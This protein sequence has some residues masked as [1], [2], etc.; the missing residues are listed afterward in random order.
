MKNN[1]FT[2]HMRALPELHSDTQKPRH[3]ILI[4]GFAPAQILDITGPLDVFAIANTLLEEMGM[5][6]YYDI[7][8]AAPE[9]GPLQTTSGIPLHASRSLFEPALAPDTLLISGGPG[10]RAVVDNTDVISA[11]QALCERTERVGS[12]CTGAFPLAATRV[13]NH[14]R[15]TTHWAHFEEFA[16]RFPEV[17]I[18]RDAIFVNDG[19][20]YTSAGISAGIDF[21]LALVESDLGRRF[22]LK[23]AREM[24]VYLKRP[25][26]QSQF[27]A[28]LAL[29]VEASDD[30]RFSDLLDWMNHNLAMDLSIEELAQR[31]AMSPRNFARR[32]VETM[33][34]APGKYVQK[35][36][37]DAARRL[38]TD[39]RLPVSRIAGMCG[40]QSAEALRLA[41]QRELKIAPTDFRQRF[42]STGVRQPV[43]P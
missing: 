32:F 15:A 34:I 40:F 14:R 17:E 28:P 43:G 11:L 37:I 25:G 36:R 2:G 31:V 6:R 30:E 20:Y 26:G 12:I 38:L 13:L 22:A 27:S 7:S 1:V 8:V 24:V 10:A 19:K 9:P 3:R 4:T 39:T 18:D 23:V 5:P 33:K 29:A 16:G 21:A 41:F 42:H 35:L